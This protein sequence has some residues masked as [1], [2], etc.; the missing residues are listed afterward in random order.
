M[1][2][3]KEDLKK[4]VN[5][6]VTLQFNLNIA[7]MIADKSKVLIEECT[8]GDQPYSEVIKE[9]IDSCNELDVLLEAAK[10]SVIDDLDN[11]TFYILNKFDRFDGDLA[12]K[13]YIT[14]KYNNL[15]FIISRAKKIRPLFTEKRV[16][17]FIKRKYR[18]AVLCFLD[19][20]FDSCCAMCRSITEILLKELCQN[21][22][23]GKGNYEEESLASLIK[24]CGNFKILK[25]AELISARRIKKTG[26]E[27]MHSK[28]PKNEKDAL[29]SIENV[30]KIFKEVFIKKK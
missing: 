9:I 29:A 2:V 26:N 3:T 13:Y 22:F 24:I 12:Q 6:V 11:T 20:K 16:P 14:E 17:V 4:A 21:K 28:T 1:R 15:P 23:S 5:N 7:K 19:G 10:E 18:E 25:E 30:Q 8:I 27:S